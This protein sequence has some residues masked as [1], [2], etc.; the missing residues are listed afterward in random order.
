MTRHRP[1]PALLRARLYQHLAAMEKAG[2]PPDR[3]CALLDLGAAGRERVA[4]FRKLA[5]RRNDPASA[6]LTSG[7]FT[8]FEARLVRTALAAGSPLETYQRLADFHATRAQQLATLRS[9]MVLPVAILAIALFVQPLPALVSGTLS[10]GAYLWR[11]LAPLLALGGAALLAARAFAWFGSGSESPA[12]AGI[13]GALLALPL[14]GPMHLRRNLRDFVDSLALLL[15]AGL[16]LFDT[17][18]VALATVGN[19]IVRADLAA[20]EPALA[21]G[22]TLAQAIAASR[23]ADTGQLHAL[24]LTGEQSGTLPAMLRR[25][26]ASETESINRFQLDLMAWLP[27]VFYALVALWMAAGILGSSLSAVAPP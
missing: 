13:E 21:S 26:A 7:L 24:V 11:V 14:F 9:R 16:P 10:A 20:M 12:R 23:L 5:A 17:M 1:L 4:A 27:R 25:H 2:L 22:A 15:E 19:R 6:G 3:A 8:V 18:P